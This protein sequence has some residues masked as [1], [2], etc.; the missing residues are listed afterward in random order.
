MTETLLMNS[1]DSSAQTLKKFREHNIPI[2]LDDFGTGYSSMSYL[3]KFDIDFL[4]IDR[5]F[6]SNLTPNSKELA[7]CQA[8]I[9]M[10]KSLGMTIIAEGIE[11]KQQQDLL[12][13]MGCDYGQGFYF[14]KP[15]RASAISQLITQQSFCSIA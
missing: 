8:I 1:D 12:T 15:V 11:T 2:A 4:K 13:T 10:A 6:V 7:L 5:S 3:S 14:S 9:T